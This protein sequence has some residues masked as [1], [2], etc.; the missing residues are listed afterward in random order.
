MAV[1]QDKVQLNI[2]FITDE[3]RNLL[4]ANKDMR[5]LTTELQNTVKKGGDVA[6]AMRRIREAGGKVEDLNLSRVAPQQLV[7]RARQLQRV[8][9]EIPET[10]PGAAR[11]QAEYQRTNHPLAYNL[12]TGRGEGRPSE[13][14]TGAASW[15]SS[16]WGP[17]AICRSQR[18]LR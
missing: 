10:A 13:L 18:P 16:T 8:L 2:E 4:K 11:L 3:S 7:T 15:A 1:R 17:V 12:R 6:D 5:A 14:E 9:Q